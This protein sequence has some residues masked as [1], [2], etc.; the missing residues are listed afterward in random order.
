[1]HGEA[2]LDNNLEWKKWKKKNEIYKNK[3]KIS[4]KLEY[5]AKTTNILKIVDVK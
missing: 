1:M 5:K 4:S 2:L 3:N